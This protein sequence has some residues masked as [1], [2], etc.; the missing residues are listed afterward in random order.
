MCWLGKQ[1]ASL[2]AQEKEDASISVGAISAEDRILF[3]TVY[4]TAKEQESSE[5]INRHL[6]LQNKMAWT[7]STLI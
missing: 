5:K 7:Q 2:S 4:H 3:N 6:V 1:Q